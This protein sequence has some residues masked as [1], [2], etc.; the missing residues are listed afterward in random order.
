MDRLVFLFPQ[1]ADSKWA[2]FPPPLMLPVVSWTV[3]AAELTPTESAQLLNA[4]YSRF[5]RAVQKHGGAFKVD[6]IG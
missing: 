4:L 5:D 1:D 6:T 3:L 2:F